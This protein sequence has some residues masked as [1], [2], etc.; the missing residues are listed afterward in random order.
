MYKLSDMLSDPHFGGFKVVA[1]SGGL[2]REV[3]TISVMDAPDI[4]Q[5]MKGGEFLITSGYAVKDDP[6]YIKDLIEKLNDKDVAGFGVK[7]DRFIHEFSNET[8]ET[9]DRLGFPI[10]SIPYRFAFTDVINPVLQEIT[11]RRSRLLAYYKQLH[12]GVTE[13]IISNASIEE[14]I[15]YLEEKAHCQICYLDTTFNRV[16][17]PRSVDESSGFYERYRGFFSQHREKEGDV[18]A[19]IPGAVPVLIKDVEYG[20]LVRG[21]NSDDYDESMA[22]YYHMAVEQV[23]IAI[24]L[25]TQKSLAEAQVET[26]YRNEFVQD[27]ITRNISS[28]DEMRN[29]AALFGW[30]FDNG[31]V[32]VIV[33]IDHFKAHYA[34]SIDEKTN[35]QLKSTIHR[36]LDT[37]IAIL[38]ER[39]NQ[40]VYGQMN[41]YIVFILDSGK[42]LNDKAAEEAFFKGLK[43]LLSQICAA[44]KSTS[45]FTVTIGTGDYKSELQELSTS[46][47]EAKRTVRILRDV[48]RDDTVVFYSELGSYRLLSMVSDTQEASRFIDEYLGPLIEYD[49]KN[50]SSYLETLDMVIRCNWNMKEA[51]SQLYIHYNSMKYR[52]RKICD[53][54]GVDLGEKDERLNVELA[55]RLHR[56]RMINGEWW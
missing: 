44:V 35:H 27:I 29:R 41:D 13:M 36:V 53:V 49:E 30:S 46:Y 12:E 2:N 11:N 47:E 50:G 24:V 45:P 32:V 16:Y 4:W 39:F 8:L 52:A 18:P 6:D 5:W 34:K 14:L 48:H 37:T 3:T 55:L 25:K 28:I 10:V 51:A 22:E 23:M 33:D 20:V 31:G 40:V 42:P 9:A 56:L 38:K 15:S 54:L 19:D 43:T 26:N 1:G 21:E 7:F 17:F